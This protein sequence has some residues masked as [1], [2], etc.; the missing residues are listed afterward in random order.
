MFIYTYVYIVQKQPSMPIPRPCHA[1]K[2][3]TSLAIQQYHT[4]EINYTTTIIFNWVNI[5]QKTFKIF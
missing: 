4:E 5:S 3:D 2:V 1:H